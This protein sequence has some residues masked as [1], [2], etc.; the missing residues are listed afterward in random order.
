MKIGD[1]DGHDIEAFEMKMTH[2]LGGQCYQ[3]VDQCG[4]LGNH[5]W[6]DSEMSQS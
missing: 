2:Q 5:K 6:R 4:N 3:T 1:E